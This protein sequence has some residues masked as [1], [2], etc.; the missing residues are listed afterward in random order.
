MT[1]R[2]LSHFEILEQIG[3]GGMGVV[4]RARDTRLDRLV[5]VKILPPEALSNP[6]RRQRFTREARSASALNH[7]NIVTIYE[8]DAAGGADFIAMEYVPGDTLAPLIGRRGLKFHDALDYAIQISGALAAAHEAGIVHRDLKP[9]NIMVTPAGQ[10]KILDFG[11]AKVMD[12]PRD[13]DSAAQALTISG[14]LTEEGL[15]VGTVAYMSPEQAEG[16]PV[17]AR[18]DI[19]SFGA[20]LYEMITGRRAFPGSTRLSTL[21]SILRDDPPSLS[22][23]V[24]AVPL[25]LERIISRCLRKDL[26][27]RFQHMGDVRVALLELKDESGSGSH[28]RVSQAATKPVLSPLR[29]IALS[30]LLLTSISGALYWFHREPPSPPRVVPFTSAPGSEKQPSFSPDGTRVAYSWDGI[31]QD[32]LDIYV[33]QIDFAVPLRLTAHPWS[34]YQPKWSPDGTRIA[35]LRSFHSTTQEII[36][37]PALAG[38]ERNLGPTAGV[39]VDWSPDNTALA[40][41][42]RPTEHEGTRVALLYVDTLKQVQLTKPALAGLD[43]GLPV[44][45]PDG[46]FLAFRRGESKWTS[47]IWMLNLNDKSVKQ[48]T[49]DNHLI[50]G[51]A[52]T[53]DGRELVF[54]SNRAGTS[55][56]WRMRAKGGAP[57]RV[58]GVEG[59]A[60]DVAIART[61]NRLAYTVP[62]NNPNIWR[63]ARPQPGTKPADPVKVISS[64]R[65]QTLPQ[66]SPDGRKVVFASNRSGSPEIWVSD[67]DGSNP[68]KLTSFGG[69]Q[70]ASPTW[71]PDGSRIAFAAQP[72]GHWLA[73][74][75]SA[76]GGIPVALP[77]QIPECVSTSWSRD[78]KSLYITSNEGGNEQVWKMATDGGGATV[79]VTKSGGAGGIES[80]DGYLYYAKG[81]SEKAVGLWRVPIG[82]GVEELVTGELR[83][84]NWNSWTLTGDGVYFINLQPTGAKVKRLIRFFDIARRR[85]ITVAEL[86]SQPSWFAGGL[87]VSPD[88]KWFLYS[89]LDHIGSNIMLMENF[90]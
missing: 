83:W 79:Q 3:S 18:T 71:S 82:G 24:P 35:F 8:I 53:L 80:P 77:R 78:G 70:L 67:S 69:P 88:G 7:P 63:L 19:F 42:N 65:Y 61:G 64:T 11:L 52:W 75:V 55:T 45:S 12:P 87:T 59:E 81:R 40:I 84:P 16:R 58:A 47:D 56:L 49:F 54:S 62:S 41:V 36:V 51:M 72:A 46:Q 57:E 26:N 85:A 38:P 30:A 89:Q 33:K 9:R 22:G 60:S 25:E 28:S 39:S 48:L 1:G 74:L 66:Y 76:E 5:A 27:R 73:Y 68:T 15:I 13:D 44:F 23:I 34:D 17:D 32:N 20:L 2:S 50:D 21:S 86:P 29:L 90:R 31:N 10:V 37:T 4:Y 14:T 6:E 43:D